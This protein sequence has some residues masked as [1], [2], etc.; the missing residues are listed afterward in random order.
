MKTVLAVSS[1]EKRVREMGS[2]SDGGITD[3]WFHT[4]WG[5]A[6]RLLQQVEHG[7]KRNQVT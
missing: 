1:T 7:M 5:T 2:L 6:H 4:L 3:I